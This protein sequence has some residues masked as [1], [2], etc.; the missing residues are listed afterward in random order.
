MNRLRLAAL[1]AIGVVL[2]ACA[3]AQSLGPY[4]SAEILPVDARSAGLYVSASESVTGLTTQLRMSFYPGIDFGFQGGFSRLEFVDGDK[5][6]LQVGA[7]VRFGTMKAAQGA[8]VDFSIGGGF[9]ID[10]GDDYNLLSVGPMA[11]LSRSFPAGAGGSS[12]PYAVAGVSFATASAGPENRTN[13]HVPINLG[14]EYRPNPVFSVAA[15]MQLRFANRFRDDIGFGVGVNF[16][17]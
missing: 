16:P 3:Q 10:V 5:T 14:A 4:T 7:D 1:A 2:P 15:E 6:L 13:V 9:G 12:V 17:F 8:P 11:F